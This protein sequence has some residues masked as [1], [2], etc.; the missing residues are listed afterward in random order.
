MEVTVP[1][2]TKG[3]VAFF[4]LWV[5]QVMKKL[6]S[7]GVILFMGAFASNREKKNSNKRQVKM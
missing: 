6:F 7:R 1:L 5:L 4:H 3:T 2:A